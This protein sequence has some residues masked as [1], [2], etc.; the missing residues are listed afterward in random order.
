MRIF[1]IIL[2]AFLAPFGAKA[3][4]SCPVSGGTAINGGTNISSAGTYYVSSGTTWTGAFQNIA[5]VNSGSIDIIICDGGTW[6]RNDIQVTSINVPLNIENSGTMDVSSMQLTDSDISFSNYGDLG[7]ANNVQFT[8]ITFDNFSDGNINAGGNV[9]LSNLQDGGTNVGEITA[10]FI[11]VAEATDFVNSGTFTAE[12]I[13]IHAANFENSGTITSTATDCSNGAGTQCGLFFGQKD[14]PII[15]LGTMTTNFLAA[16]GTSS[17]DPNAST[18]TIEV[19]TRVDCPSQA[20]WEVF[21]DNSGGAGLS[22]NN[23]GSQQSSNTPTCSVVP[24]I[25]ME[26]TGKTN[27]SVVN[28]Q[29]MTASEIGFSHFEL[30]QSSDGIRFEKIQEVTNP[31]GISGNYKIYTASLPFTR[32]AYIRL[33][34]VDLNGSY[35]YSEVLRFSQVEN[36]VEVFP[37]PLINNVLNIRIE[38]NKG[39]Q[40]TVYS[41]DGSVIKRLN[42]IESDLI[43]LDL[44]RDG[45]SVYLVEVIQD[46]DIQTFKVIR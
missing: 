43:E 39:A 5:N 4:T 36:K 27:G 23:C 13:Y 15:N 37:N 34:M 20:F 38:E 19:M 17:I 46:S 22:Y 29:W 9:I 21:C 32:K 3:Q 26:F 28:A 12:D 45:N 8:N 7:A 33:K 2:L 16:S 44:P 14:S 24:V 18:G 30:E 6:D 41:A 40:V 11:E 1:T 42:N 25:L 35:E 31:K 10:N